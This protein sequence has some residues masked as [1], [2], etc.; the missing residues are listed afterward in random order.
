M[1]RS[2]AV[3]AR[4]I[5][6]VGVVIR[7]IA[8]V[9]AVSDN[10]IDAL[11]LPDFGRLP[12]AGWGGD[13]GCRKEQA[14]R[15]H[16]SQAFGTIVQF[17]RDV[18]VAGRRLKQKGEQTGRFAELHQAR[19]DRAYRAAGAVL[20][21]DECRPPRTH[22]PMWLEHR[23]AAF[24]PF[25][26]GLAYITRSG[27]GWT[28]DSWVERVGKMASASLSK[29]PGGAT[30]ASQAFHSAVT[31]LL[32]LPAVCPRRSVNGP[33]SRANDRYASWL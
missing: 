13:R 4:V 5:V 30:E 29:R 10:L 17:G 22:V 19:G 27:G 28:V 24:G 14:R 3:A 2:A 23:K 32:P 15:R 26:I 7:R 6:P 1:D 20:P 33:L 16:A 31:N 11:A 9:E 12:G 18:S 8:V 21:A 25:T